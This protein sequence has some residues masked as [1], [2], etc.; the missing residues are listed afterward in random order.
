[1]EL[2]TGGIAL[3]ST[4]PMEV[5]PDLCVSFNARDPGQATV[6]KYSMEMPGRDFATPLWQAIPHAKGGTDE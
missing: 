5:C 1:M 2:R 3:S 4:L 6:N